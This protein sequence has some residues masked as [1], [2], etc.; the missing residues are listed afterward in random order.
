[1]LHNLLG[2]AERTDNP[3]E[4]IRYLDVILALNPDSAP[5]RLERA[6]L[7]MR[8]GS[9][10]SAKEDLRWLLDHKP[11]GVDLERLEELFRSL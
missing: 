1:M 8:R 9:S 6:R 2:N 10:A 3:S 5:D 7:Q 11:A 4:A